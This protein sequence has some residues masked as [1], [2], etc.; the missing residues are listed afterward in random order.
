MSPLMLRRGQ[1]VRRGGQTL[2]EVGFLDGGPGVGQQRLL[3]VV[4]ERAQNSS[5]CYRRSDS[6]TDC[7]ALLLSENISYNSHK[8]PSGITF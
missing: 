8:A 5:V 1:A 6:T 4:S 7:A 3:Q 2:T